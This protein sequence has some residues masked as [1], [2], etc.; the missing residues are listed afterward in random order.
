MF[1]LGL[2]YL[3][4]RDEHQRPILVVKPSKIKKH[5]V[6]DALFR[7]AL[8]VYS[9]IIRQHC[10]RQYHPENWVMIIDLDKRSLTEFPFK[11]LKLLITCTSLFF[12]GCLHKM[13]LLNP[14]NF[15]LLTFKIIEKVMDAETRPKLQMMKLAAFTQ[16]FEKN[17]LSPDEI[18][19]EFGGLKQDLE[20][21][22]PPVLMTRPGPEPPRNIFEV[23]NSN[24]QEQESV[25]RESKT[26]PVV[27]PRSIGK[28]SAGNAPLRRVR[29]E[30]REDEEGEQE[31]RDQI[32]VVDFDVFLE[33]NN[34]SSHSFYSRASGRDFL[35]KQSK[36]L[37]FKE[38]V[39]LREQAPSVSSFVRPSPD[40]SMQHCA[41]PRGQNVISFKNVDTQSQIKQYPAPEQRKAPRSHLQGPPRKMGTLGETSSHLSF[42]RSQT[43]D[44]STD[45]SYSYYVKKKNQT[46][47]D[48]ITQI[49]SSQISPRKGRVQKR[50][51][52][53]VLLEHQR[54]SMMGPAKS[55]T[56]KQEENE[57]TLRKMRTMDLG[58]DPVEAPRATFTAKTFKP[59][60]VKKK[61]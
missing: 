30:R 27:F 26:Q 47:Q 29:A 21:Y 58:L 32:T 37:R 28:L 41:I 38:G 46:V 45:Y 49:R 43:G 2:F 35:R 9:Q 31:S 17:G 15:F 55:L 52:N 3:C 18:P 16:S 36:F 7:R 4:G 61:K 5:A 14:T 23:H 33:S 20:Q 24:V 34:C 22:W 51:R 50:V 40:P 48:L 13:Y 44:P 1:R 8:V 6:D 39:I 59:F 19:T 60:W 54:L 56:L 42:R 10:F 12:A 25:I 11:Q 57:T 53:S